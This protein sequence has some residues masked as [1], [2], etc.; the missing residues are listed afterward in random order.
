[1]HPHG[2]TAKAQRKRILAY[3]H[4]K[5]LDTLS[6]RK[7]LDVMHPAARVM[8]LRNQGIEIKTIW[9]DRASDCG[10]VHRIACYV[11]ADA[12]ATAP[13]DTRAG[14]NRQETDTT[15]HSMEGKV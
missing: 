8:E 13:T 11:L 5:P 12:A 14:I 1:M 10:K 3:L 15:E 9:I 4:T 7:E 2:N 6:A